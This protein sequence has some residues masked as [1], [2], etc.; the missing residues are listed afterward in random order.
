[1]ASD[2]DESELDI[3]YRRPGF[4]MRRAHQISVSLFMDEAAHLG[5]TTTQYGALVVLQSHQDLDQFGLAKLVGIDRSTAALV[6]SKL[7]AA[8]LITRQQDSTDLRRKVLVLTVKGHDMLRQVA[9]PAQRAH[10]R[11]LSAFTPKQAE[12]F[13]NL[14]SRFVETFNE[15]ARVPIHK[16]GHPAERRRVR[17]KGASR[18]R[19]EGQ[20]RDGAAHG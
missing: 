12:T 1:M 16:A 5:L 4:L 7:D 8:G 14:L 10:D 6:V 11:A 18:Q 3:L 2:K 20:R 17:K 15:N 19:A 13:L 9:E